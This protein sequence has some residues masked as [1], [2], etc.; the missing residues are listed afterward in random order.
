[1]NLP[2]A[3]A[4]IPGNGGRA[5]LHEPLAVQYVHADKYETYIARRDNIHRTWPRICRSC[6]ME[7]R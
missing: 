1:M 6:E 3:Y 2:P 5:V 7:F 4:R